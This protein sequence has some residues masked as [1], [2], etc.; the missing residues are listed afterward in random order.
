M[1]GQDGRVFDE[2]GVGEAEIGGE[3][4]DR[5]A[6]LLEGFAVEGVLLE[7]FVNVRG[8]EVYGGEAFG[9]VVSGQPD[10]GVLEQNLGSPAMMVSQFRDW[11]GAG[12]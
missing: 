9:E 6:A 12:S 10:D 8:A 7:D 1:R 4:G 5:Q 3:S 2:G 11:F